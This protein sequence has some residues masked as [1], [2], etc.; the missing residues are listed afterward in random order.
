MKPSPIKETISFIDF[1]KLDIRVGVILFL[2]LWRVYMFR[3]IKLKERIINNKASFSRLLNIDIGSH[4]AALQGNIFGN[5]A[6]L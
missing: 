5:S 3:E 2:Q 4:L 1:E 6:Q